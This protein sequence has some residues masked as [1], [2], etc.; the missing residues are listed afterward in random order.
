[1]YQ[2]CYIEEGTFLFSLCHLDGMLVKEDDCDD[3]GR[4]Q[5]NSKA[6]VADK[7]QK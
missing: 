3:Q 1:L 7:Y 6:N 2:Q 4:S 5:K